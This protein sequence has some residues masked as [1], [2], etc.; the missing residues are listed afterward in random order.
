[1][2]DNP[3]ISARSL[4]QT[5]YSLLASSY[6]WLFGLALFWIISAKCCLPSSKSIC[7][8][9]LSNGAYLSFNTFVVSVTDWFQ[10]SGVFIW[11]D[12]VFL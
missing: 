1:M 3:S 7:F 2:S 5:L 6:N 12:P 10:T 4:D 8:N 9:R 11:G